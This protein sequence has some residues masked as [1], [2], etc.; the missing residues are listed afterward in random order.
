MIP[1]TASL[2]RPPSSAIPFRRLGPSPPLTPRREFRARRESR[3][4]DRTSHRRAQ[5]IGEECRLIDDDV[6][7]LA[8]KQ[9]AV[10]LGDEA[11]DELVREADRLANRHAEADEVFG[12]LV[13]LK[14]VGAACGHTPSAQRCLFF[15]SKEYSRRRLS[16]V[17]PEIRARG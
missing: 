4:I 5:F 12:V 17:D 7:N 2:A 16:E 15:L 8:L 14:M 11:L 6:E 3:A 13:R 10:A 9:R 1:L